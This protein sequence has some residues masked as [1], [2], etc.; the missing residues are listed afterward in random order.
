MFLFIYFYIF[1]DAA[2]KQYK[3][4]HKHINVLD[5][6]SGTCKRDW[7][8]GLEK[9]EKFRHMHKIEK[10]STY[11]IHV[12]TVYEIHCVLKCNTCMNKVKTKLVSS[13][14]SGENFV[15]AHT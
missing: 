6:D 1:N 14:S 13:Y 2:W 5:S 8:F 3:N 7:R 15:L 10:E 9:D 4:S 11:I 12:D